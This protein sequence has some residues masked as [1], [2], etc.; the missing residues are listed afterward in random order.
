M[1]TKLR[2]DR[3]A[4]RRQRQAIVRALRKSNGN[5]AATARKFGVKRELVAHL[6]DFHGIAAGQANPMRSE[7]VLRRGSK[8]ERERA[9]V[10]NALKI[11]NGNVKRAVA[12]TGI[13]ETT[14]RR[15]KAERVPV[16]RAVDP[17][18]F[19]GATTRDPES[20]CLIWT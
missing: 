19:F 4:V 10:Q 3:L 5:V 7:A 12:E 9:R 13:A 16:W 2:D 8:R 17:E 11:A 1:S 6:R 15:W 14:V 20:G 18:R